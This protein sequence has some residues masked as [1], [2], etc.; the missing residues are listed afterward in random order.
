MGGPTA[1]PTAGYPSRPEGTIR[2]YDVV[3]FGATGFTGQLVAEVLARHTAPEPGAAAIP[4]LRWAIAG[5]D[6]AK[7]QDLKTSLVGIDPANGRVGTIRVDATDPASLREMAAQARIVITTVGP[8]MVH[9][10][11]V[12][13]ACVAAKTHCLDLTGEPAFVAETR[14]RFGAEAAAN[15]LRIVHCCGFDSVPADLG[16]LFTVSQLPAGVPKQVRCY[17]KTNA[18]FSGGTWA[19]FVGAAGAGPV[20]VPSPEPT[21]ERGDT[22]G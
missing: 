18:S 14:A 15:G 20:R 19:S 12:V 16:A 6:P 13:E 4:A 3:L 9:G 10:L 5:R 21:G 8:Y 1:G 22:G 11:P 2:P 7:L 17:V